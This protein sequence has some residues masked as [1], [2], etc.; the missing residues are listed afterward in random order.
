MHLGSGTWTYSF[1]SG[2]VRSDRAIAVTRRP[3]RQNR[4]SFFVHGAFVQQYTDKVTA[5]MRPSATFSR[6][7]QAMH[8][9]H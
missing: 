7:L 6:A 4:P 2:A 3:S 5:A 1:P 9:S 8:A